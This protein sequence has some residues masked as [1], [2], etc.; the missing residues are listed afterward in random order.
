MTSVSS[1][2]GTI[3]MAKAGRPPDRLARSPTRGTSIP[4]PITTAVTMPMA[5]NGAGTSLVMRGACQITS[6]VRMIMLMVA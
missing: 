2:N 4:K 6:M 1:V 5:V 3:G